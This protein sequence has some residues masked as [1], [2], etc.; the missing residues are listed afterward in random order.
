LAFIPARFDHLVVAVRSLPEGIAQ[1]EWMTGVRPG[2]GGRHPDRGTENAL[3]SLGDGAYLE[4][5]A[6]QPGATLAAGDE[7]MRTMEQLQIIAWAVAVADV[8]DAAAELRQ[9]GAAVGPRKPGSRVAPSAERLEW[10]T[11][12]LEDP[13][14]VTAPFFIQWTAETRHPSETAPGGCTLAGL[15][16]HDPAADRLSAILAAVRVR[17]VNCVTGAPRIDAHLV[18]GAVMVTLSS[19]I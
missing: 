19:E 8:D 3:V 9:A 7:R 4:I 18:C 15:T 6:P 13:S 12:T 10:T 2:A 11:F 16:V 17:R 1:F 5:I 14:P